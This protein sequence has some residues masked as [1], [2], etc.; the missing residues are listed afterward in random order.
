[1]QYSKHYKGVYVLMEK[2]DTGSDKVHIPKPDDTTGVGGY[3]LKM[4]KA[5]VGDTAIVPPT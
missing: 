4:D 5:S 3:I 1:M 2:V